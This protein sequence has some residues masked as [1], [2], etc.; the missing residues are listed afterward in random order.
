MTKLNLM[1]TR[2]QLSKENPTRKPTSFESKSH[3]NQKRTQSIIMTLWR[4]QK[5]ES[6]EESDNQ[7]V[8][9][10]D[11]YFISE[12]DDEDHGAI[13]LTSDAADTNIHLITVISMPGTN[14]MI[15]A[16]SCLINQCCTG[17]GMIASKFVKI[18][19]FTSHSNKSMLI[20]YC[21]WNTDNGL[22]RQLDTCQAP[23]AF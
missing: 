10:A 21:K 11:F 13:L 22:T 16:T 18:L 4:I 2:R 3:S 23:D 19:G 1:V 15:R 7:S 20:Q 14:G 6:D 17:S 8:I 12:D 5:S 9:S